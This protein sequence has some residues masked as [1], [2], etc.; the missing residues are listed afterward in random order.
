MDF[1]VG[2]LRSARHL[3]VKM[4]MAPHLPAIM[5]TEEGFVSLVEL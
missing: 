2:N 4:H 1:F 5:M 3:V